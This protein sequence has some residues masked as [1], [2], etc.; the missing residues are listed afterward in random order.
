V[1]AGLDTAR[2]LGVRVLTVRAT[3]PE[4]ELS[5]VSLGDL[6]AEVPSVELGS[7]PPPQLRVLE[8]ALLRVEPDGVAPEPPAVAAASAPAG[9]SQLSLA[10]LK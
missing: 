7:L 9:S 10:A 1:E 4:S 2:R 5:Y 6:L 3:E 8:V